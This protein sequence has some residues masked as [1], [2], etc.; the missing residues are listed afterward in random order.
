MRTA[1]AFSAGGVFVHESLD[2]REPDEQRNAETGAGHGL[3]ASH[4]PRI[5]EELAAFAG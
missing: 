5:V 2:L 4:A 1:R 3:Y